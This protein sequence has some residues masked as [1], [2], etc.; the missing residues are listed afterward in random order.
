MGVF[1][2]F[3]VVSV[4]YARYSENIYGIKESSFT[5]GVSVLSVI[6]GCVAGASLFLLGVMDTY[7]YHE[8]HT[9]F[10]A[11]YFS[12]L[13]AC[14]VGTCVVYWEQIWYPSPF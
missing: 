5:R 2:I 12:G 6:S 9:I 4:H 7:R 14:A 3:T 11:S 8:E 10:L 13:V 1:F